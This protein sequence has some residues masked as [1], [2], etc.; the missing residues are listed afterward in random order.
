MKLSDLIHFQHN[1]GR[2]QEIK[3]DRKNIV[4]FV[5]AGISKGCGLYTWGELLRQ[6]AVDYLT[7]EDIQKVEAKGDFFA[8]ADQIVSAAGNSDMI[9]KRIREILGQSKISMTEIP[10]LLVSMFSPMVITTNYD[11]LLED[12]SNMSPLGPIKP[13][14]PC[15]VGQM[16][17]TIQIND[18]RLLK[19][20][21]SI[22]ETQSFIFT[23][24]QYRKF[25]GEKDSREDKLLPRYL[26]KI[27]SAKKILFLGCSLE[28]DY[29][30]DI[31]EESVQQNHS[32]SHFAILSCPSDDRRKIQRNNELAKLGIQPIYYPEGDH[33]AL[34]KLIY[35][36]AES[37]HFISSTEQILTERLGNSK[38]TTSQ[39]QVL[40]SLMKESYY[41]TA[42]RFPSL[43]D[44]D[45]AKNDYTECMTSFLK[46]SRH[47]PDTILDLCK[48]VFSAYVKCG[49]LRCE[50][51]TIACFF[52]QLE[53]E[54]LKE[55]IIEPL[56]QK[57]WSIQHHLSDPTQDDLSWLKYT[58]DAEINAV[59][60]SVL[61]KLQ[62]SNGMNYDIYNAYC[63]AKGLIKL[64][65]ERI[66]FEVRIRLL[67]SVGA[68]GYRFQDCQTAII[69]LERAIQVIDKCGDTSRE[70]MLLKAKCYANLAITK[71]Y[72]DNNLYPVLDAA[73]N[74]T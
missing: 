42:M 3:K 15:L 55:D 27:F 51:A 48:S 25:Y 52:E 35:F 39:I 6:I 29:T 60:N 32:I 16:N 68:F 34:N 1:E 11:T 45:N 57:Q 64:A 12:A 56:L 37:N 10:Y 36:I 63:M 38:K 2:L 73:E 19:I 23:G 49:Y 70:R 41:K 46:T 71:G 66:D 69:C 7:I 8:Y 44:I 30:L 28:R 20:H 31:L 4:P 59:A 67:N 53:K 22:E 62:Y 17:E 26:M 18:R 40:L 5:G 54:V 24:E 14:L 9:M 33:Q 47:Q 58:S 65:E 13:L 72:H 21:G 43:L 74:I 50:E 61:Q